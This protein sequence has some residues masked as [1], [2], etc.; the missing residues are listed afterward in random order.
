M[1]AR[2]EIMDMID[3]FPPNL[4]EDLRLY[5]KNKIDSYTPSRTPEQEAFMQDVYQKLAESEADFA[6]GRKSNAR[7]H[8]KQLREEFNV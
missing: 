2:Q 5:M 4:F 3:V 8:L 7:E 6:A 1:Q